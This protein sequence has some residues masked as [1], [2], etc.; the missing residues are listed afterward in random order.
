[1]GAFDIAWISHATIGVAL[2]LL[3]VTMSVL[4]I[5][6]LMKALKANGAA[7]PYGSL[8]RLGVGVVAL[9]AAAV[10]FWLPVRSGESGEQTEMFAAAAVALGLASLVLVV[11]GVRLLFSLSLGKRSAPQFSIALSLLFVGVGAGLAS[12]IAAVPGELW[13]R[14]ETLSRQDWF[15][16]NFELFIVVVGVLLVGLGDW[17]G[18]AWERAT[19]S[20]LP[21]DPKMPSERRAEIEADRKAEETARHRLVSSYSLIF[22]CAVSVSLLVSIGSSAFSARLAQQQ[23][24]EARADGNQIPRGRI[25]TAIEQI[26]SVQ[27]AIDEQSR[28]MDAADSRIDRAYSQTERTRL[29]QREVESQFW[30]EFSSLHLTLRPGEVFVQ[31]EGEFAQTSLSAIAALQAA[32][33][34]ESHAALAPLLQKRQEALLLEWNST[35]ANAAWFLRLNERNR[36]EAERARRENQREC[37][38]QRLAWAVAGSTG[39][40]TGRNTPVSAPIDTTDSATRSSSASGQTNSP[41]TT[42]PQPAQTSNQAVQPAGATRAAALIGCEGLTEAANNNDFLEASRLIDAGLPLQRSWMSSRL[43]RRAPITLSIE[44][45]LVMGALGALLRVAAT[46]LRALTQQSVPGVANPMIND[47][48]DALLTLALNVVF[49]MATALALFILMSVTINASSL[50]YSA[51]ANLGDDLNPFTMAGFGLLGGFSA[52]SVADWMD[53]LTR[54]LLSKRR[55]DD[56]S[57]RPAGPSTPNQPSTPVATQNEAGAKPPEN[58]D[59]GLLMVLLGLLSMSPETLERVRTALQEEQQRRTQAPD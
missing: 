49:G 31:P 29:R 51:E 17:V 34:V 2:A 6:S 18:R 48:Q 8:Q 59:P 20:D 24:E 37:V 42:S 14:S 3:G 23:I 43:A 12:L 25:Q 28:K 36:A 30:T 22:A 55:D 33:P 32:I 39:T 27:D 38:V 7:K 41:T 46:R 15:T 50:H 58:F 35:Q 54:D 47:D 56:G 5:S 9:F 52:L 10:T 13:Q 26:D 11:W 4:S 19:I 53:K 44:L 45:V 57:A 21:V 16:D 40:S 1:M